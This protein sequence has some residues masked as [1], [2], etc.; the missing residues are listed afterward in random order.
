MLKMEKGQKLLPVSLRK[1]HQS[2]K[3]YY[4][5]DRKRIALPPGKRMSKMGKLYYEYRKNRTDLGLGDVPEEPG[6]TQ[7]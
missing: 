3:S 6:Y 2:G 1:F 7:Q 4:W 5:K